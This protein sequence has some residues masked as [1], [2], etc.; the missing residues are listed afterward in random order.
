MNEIQLLRS[1]IYPGIP[2]L[3]QIYEDDEKIYLV[4]DLINGDTLLKKLNE[5]GKFS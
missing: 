4:Q 1:L 3:H 5:A 2:A